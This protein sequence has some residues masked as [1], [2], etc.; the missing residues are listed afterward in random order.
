[1]SSGVRTVTV[2][3]V[4]LSEISVMLTVDSVFV[5]IA[6]QAEPVPSKFVC[7]CATGHVVILPDD[8]VEEG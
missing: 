7:S 4:V 8:G 6:S 1:V 2:M 3:S 5:V